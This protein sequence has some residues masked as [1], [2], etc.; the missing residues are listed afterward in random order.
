MK[1]MRLHKLL[2]LPSTLVPKSRSSGDRL[3]LLQKNGP[4]RKNLS[5]K[6][7]LYELQ[8]KQ[9]PDNKANPYPKPMLSVKQLRMSYQILDLRTLMRTTKLSRTKMITGLL[10]FWRLL[11]QFLTSDGSILLQLESGAEWEDQKRL[12]REK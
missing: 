7:Q 11:E 10:V 3:K 6:N 2:M 1:M 12:L 9:R 4:E 5:E 8:L